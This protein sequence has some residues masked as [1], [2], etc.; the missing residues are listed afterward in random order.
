MPSGGRALSEDDLSDHGA[1]G[2]PPLHDPVAAYSQPR[3]RP[4]AMRPTTAETASASCATHFSSSIAATP[5]SFDAG[6]VRVD[7]YTH[8]ASVSA[9]RKGVRGNLQ[10]EAGC[11]VI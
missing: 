9:N 2:S 3:R 11:R 7:W 1:A 4:C 10:V 6:A 5:L 8:R